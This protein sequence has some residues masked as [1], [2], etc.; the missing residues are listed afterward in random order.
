M[1]RVWLVGYLPPH[2]SL[3]L[4]W[5]FSFIS[6]Y[7]LYRTVF[8]LTR[9]RM[10]ARL[11]V[12]LYAIS[13]GFLSPL[14]MVTI[15]AKAFANSFVIFCLYLAAKICQSGDWRAYSTKAVV[16]YMALL[17]AYC[18]D[19]TAWVIYGA[20]PIM[21][22]SLFQRRHLGLAICL[23]STFALYL[24]FVTWLAPIATTYYW[25]R[26]GYPTMD[27]WGWTFN[28]GSHATPWL[29][30]LLARLDLGTI[31][32][33]T[34]NISKFEF[35][36]PRSGGAAAAASVLPFAAGI[37]VAAARAS[38]QL[39]W[40]LTRAIILLVLFAIYQGLVLSRLTSGPYQSTYYYGALAA[41]FSAVVIGIT[42]GC[43]RGM[44][45]ARAACVL[46]ACY[47]GWVSCA[48]LLRD[49]RE[50]MDSYEAD[51][52]NMYVQGGGRDPFMPGAT[53]TL[54]KVVK[55]WRAAQVGEDLTK[56]RAAF[57]PKDVW[58][59]ELMDH[60]LCT[61]RACCIWPQR[62]QGYCPKQTCSPP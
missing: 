35:A 45:A 51:Y 26:E 18:T 49:N 22:P 28:L 1:F 17:L 20:L 21:F 62:L 16:L 29:S 30:P 11:A 40:R 27:F 8:A 13:E 54:A 2:P 55:Y 61:S 57:S 46:A 50:E 48:N 38:A 44:P 32:S 42:V 14:L 39:R 9:D 4:T 60:K 31:L 56:L 7:F 5:F 43:F 10:A 36:W 34:W 33:T 53:L 37:G 6:L 19:E 58:L 15:P 23:L 12:G 59:F 25:A 47:L 41:V 3:S 52:A 24:A